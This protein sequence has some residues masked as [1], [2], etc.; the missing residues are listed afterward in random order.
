MRLELC[1]GLSGP[2]F[3]PM[4]NLFN[5]NWEFFEL[6]LEESSMYKDGKPVLFSP[7]QFFES[8]LTYSYKPVIV[9]H[10]WMIHHVK[11]LYENSVGFYK[12]CF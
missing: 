1:L 8:A 10:D 2:F 7:D 12:K 11:E 3:M 6:P 9:P 4:R 5:D